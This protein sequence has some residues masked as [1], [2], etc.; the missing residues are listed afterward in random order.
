MCASADV[1]AD[2]LALRCPGVIFPDVQICR[3]GLGQ[4]RVKLAAEPAI[5]RVDANQQLFQMCIWPAARCRQVKSEQRI[6]WP[7][8]GEV[9][10]AKPQP[11][12][13]LLD[14]KLSVTREL[15]VPGDRDVIEGDLGS[16]RMK[17]RENILR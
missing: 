11:P 14:I 12:V 9:A 8:H 7:R 2:R 17:P 4:A 1:A 6:L 5:H 15:A 13:L 3:D 16:V 10:T